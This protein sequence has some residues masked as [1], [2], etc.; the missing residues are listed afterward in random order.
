[1]D[2]FSFKAVGKD[3]KMYTNFV[4]AWTYNDK[5]Y[6]LYVKPSFVKDLRVIKAKSIKV[7]NYD[8]VNVLK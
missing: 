1:M 8:A 4:L 3:G 6:R 5:M 2:L 7:N